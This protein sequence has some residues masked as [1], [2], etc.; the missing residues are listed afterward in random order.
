MLARCWNQIQ[1]PI[2]HEDGVHETMTDEYQGI[3]L[4]KDDY[5]VI[6]ELEQMVG[7]PLP[8]LERP[9]DLIRKRSHKFGLF[10]FSATDGAIT[11][12]A[13]NSQR[14]K[15][16]PATIGSLRSLQNLDARNNEL[17]ELPESFGQLVSLQTLK[18]SKNKLDFLPETFGNASSLESIDISENSLTYLPESFCNLASLKEL[19]A[20]SNNITTLP[21]S[22]GS[23]AKLQTLRFTSNKL[24]ALPESFVQLEAL[25]TC[26]LDRN[27]LQELP[28]IIGN[29]RSLKDLNLKGNGMIDLPESI[30]QL[31]FL[32]TLDVGSN[33]LVALPDSIG[34]LTALQ[35]LDLRSNE[36]SSLPDS[37]QNLVNLRNYYMGENNF[38][39][40]PLVTCTLKN[41]SNLDMAGN[42]LKEIPEE[43]KGLA[44]LKEIYLDRNKLASIPVSLRHL[45]ALERISL[46]ANPFDA[47]SAEIAGRDAKTIIEFC[48]KKAGI[49]IFISHAVID[50]ETYHV[51][52]LATYLKQQPGI[53][54][55]FYCE[56][57]LVGNIDEFMD[58]TVPQCQLVLF[59]ATKKSVTASKDCAHELDLARKHGIPIMIIKGSDVTAAD[60]DAL[61]L[62]TRSEL[63][64]MPDDF[65]GFTGSLYQAITAFKDAAGRPAQDVA[66]IDEEIQRFANV[67]ESLSDSEAFFSLV[68]QHLDQVKPLIHD[69]SNDVVSGSV[70]IKKM[71]DVFNSGDNI[72][73]KH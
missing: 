21:A 33:K 20:S 30:G 17:R 69:F 31:T 48:K 51:A 5:D 15:E 44:M 66:S 61:S 40:F 1:R 14:L 16:L 71:S 35:K 72:E 7:N 45:Q 8:V 56:E 46:D 32:E 37:M 24:V 58:M 41:L 4:N 67:I 50:F 57:N 55:A 26:K 42:Q 2:I 9:I 10:G 25:S 47:E 36:L 28:L 22:F 64:F 63:E 49:Q 59:L 38:T 43:I 23:I 6:M 73:K 52:D 60:I 53:F 12:L 18:L 34:Q 70:F 3:P 11:R 19:D 29:L 65:E 27:L 13:L 68:E 62:D 54:D 39:E